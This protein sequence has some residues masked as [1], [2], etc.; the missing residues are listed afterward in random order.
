MHFDVAGTV[1]GTQYWNKNNALSKMCQRKRLPFS[2]PR[3]TPTL[4][5]ND[6]TL[7]N[8]QQIK[9]SPFLEKNPTSIFKFQFFT[10]PSTR[11]GIEE[12]IDNAGGFLFGKF[13]LSGQLGNQF[14]FV[15]SSN[16]CFNQ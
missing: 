4:Q 7:D 11:K 15:H 5:K 12:Q 9:I 16:P 2:T 10:F 3:F 6:A 14:E 1:S 13:L 8:Q